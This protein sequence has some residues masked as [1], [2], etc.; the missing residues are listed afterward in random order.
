M[1]KITR[2]DSNERLSKVVIHGDTIYIAG[3][4]GGANNY[5]NILISG[6]SCSEI[7]SAN[8]VYTNKITN[9]RVVFNSSIDA[10]D[11]V[12]HGIGNLTSVEA[13]NSP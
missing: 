12:G 4:T 2:I 7:G 5:T 8:Y 10:A 1:T 9:L 13:Y 6:N 11:A 3:T